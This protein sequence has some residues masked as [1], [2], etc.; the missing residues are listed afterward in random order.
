MTWPSVAPLEVDVRL[1]GRGRIPESPMRGRVSCH[2]S[3]ILLGQF[4]RKSAGITVL[5]RE[6]LTVGYLR[7][8]RSDSI[9]KHAFAARKAVTPVGS[10]G[11]ETSTQSKP[12]KSR[13]CGARPLGRPPPRAGAAK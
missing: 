11:G 9:S 2:G 6:R 4:A 13:L 10:Y 3:T 5:C 8:A 1:R 12:R 7:S